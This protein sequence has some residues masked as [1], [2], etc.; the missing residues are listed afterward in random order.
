VNVNRIGIVVKHLSTNITAM[1]LRT[2]KLLRSPAVMIGVGAVAGM[3]FGLIVGDWAANLQ[4][5][6]DM[7]IRLIQMSIVPLVM[8][9][10]IVATGSMSGKGTGLVAAR[11]FGWMFAFSFLAAVLAW[12]L[13]SVIRPGDG[14]VFTGELD[15][16]LQEG[17]QQAGTWQDTLLGFVSTNV[18]EAMANADML[19][20]IVFSLIFGIAFEPLHGADREPYVDRDLRGHPG[21]GAHHDPVRD[22]HRPGRGLLPVGVPDR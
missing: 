2:R 21:R 10:V 1:G 19:P 3:V 18:V 11:T 16:S 4:F 17:A 14:M 5:I 20:I 8:A 12:G 22:V 7:F 9:S 6:G 15:P 13:G